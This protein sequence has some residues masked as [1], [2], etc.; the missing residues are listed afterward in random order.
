MLG[1][2]DFQHPLFAPF[3]DPRFSDFTRIHFGNIAGSIRRKSPARGCWRD[4]TGTPM[5]R[6][7]NSVGTGRLFVL[8]SGWHPGT[9]SW[10]CPRSSCR[11]FYSCWN[12][13]R[14]QRHAGAIP[15]RD[16][17]TPERGATNSA[18]GHLPQTGWHDGRF[19]SGQRK[20]FGNG[21]ARHLHNHM[22]SRRRFA[23]ISI[24]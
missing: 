20:F 16:A 10:P 19:I 22:R 15:G 6:S 8:T 18:A 9:A 7:R 13:R 1:E 3:A 23:S 24:R 12:K 17:V 11:C 5:R 14:R 4:S 21:S 2:I